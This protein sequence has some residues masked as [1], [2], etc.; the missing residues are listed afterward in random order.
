MDNDGV[1]W[2]TG[3]KSATLLA[4]SSQKLIEENKNHAINKYRR[5]WRREGLWRPG[6]TF[7]QPPLLA[8]GP[9]QLESLGLWGAP[10]SP[11]CELGGAPAEDEI[12]CI[13]T[14]MVGGYR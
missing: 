11:A 10:Q 7:A 1:H 9:S 6:Q 13:I 4:Q 12:W 3:C 5:Q 14:S 8:G 2:A